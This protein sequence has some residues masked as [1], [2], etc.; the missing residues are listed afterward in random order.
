M[1]RGKARAPFNWARYYE[2]KHSNS[3]SRE[4]SWVLKCEK[5]FLDHWKGKGTPHMEAMRLWEE[6]K[7]PDSA[8]PSDKDAAGNWLCG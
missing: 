2:E 6:A 5:D 3:I 8:T 7:L 4:V 1:G